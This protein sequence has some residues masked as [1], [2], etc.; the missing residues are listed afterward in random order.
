LGWGGINA[1]EN[2]QWQS[3]AEARAK[4]KW[5]RNGGELP[6]ATVRVALDQNLRWNHEP[7]FDGSV[8]TAGRRS[9]ALVALNLISPTV[10]LDELGTIW[11]QTKMASV[12][13]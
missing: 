10:V 12:S 3:V 5:D 2:M 6:V 4:D 11:A 8:T 9:S 7:R 13:H 1:P